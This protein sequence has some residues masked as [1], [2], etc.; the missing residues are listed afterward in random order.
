MLADSSASLAVHTHFVLERQLIRLGAPEG[1]AKTSK[2]FVRALM[3]AKG[4][5]NTL[6]R[7]EMET[8]EVGVCMSVCVGVCVCVL[9]TETSS[10]LNPSITSH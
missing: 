4:A 9:R 3:A 1:T 2:H 7:L 10:L 8:E 5:D 6:A